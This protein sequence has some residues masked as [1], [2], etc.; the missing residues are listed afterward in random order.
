MATDGNEVEAGNYVFAYT[1][2]DYSGA[3]F[4]KLGSA[5]AI[6]EGKAYLSASA[7]PS[8]SGSIK[9]RF[10]DDTATAIS[11]I[12]NDSSKLDGATYNLA[13]QRVDA[14]YKGIVIRNGKKYLIK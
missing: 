12:A 3:G 9:F 7:V 14:S 4:Y 8:G 5:T 10:D 13:G 1:T 11:T 6:A 2:S